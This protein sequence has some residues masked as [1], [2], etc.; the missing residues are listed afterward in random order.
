MKKK[1]FHNIGP[2]FGIFLVAMAIWILH[3]ELRAY[4]FHDIARHLRELPAHRLLLALAFTT[5]SYFI[6]TGYDT[7]ALRYIR[8]PLGYARTALA[9]FIGYAFSNNIGFS[10]IAGASV[11]Y[12][13]YL[14]WGLSAIETTKVVIFASLTLWIGF[15]TIGGI[16]LLFEP[17]LDFK[18]LHLPFASV[19]P[20]GRRNEE[21]RKDGG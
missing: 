13:L 10:A 8:H 6:L 11:R 18:A 9:S 21:R 1:F 12:R 17:M 16:I 20:L 3:H 15:C 7:L 4:H 2:L 19:H 5:L 14:A